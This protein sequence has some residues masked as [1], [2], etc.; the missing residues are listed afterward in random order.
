MLKRGADREVKGKEEGKWKQVRK[1]ERGKRNTNRK[2]EIEKST[3]E[4]RIKK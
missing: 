1:L 3:K 2:A 4:E